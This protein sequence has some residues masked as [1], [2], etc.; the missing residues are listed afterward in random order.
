MKTHRVVV[1]HDG[2]T[3]IVIL[4]C[5]VRDGVLTVS[6]GEIIRVS[7]LNLNIR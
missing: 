4:N 5:E 7:A 2:L 6:V 3:Y 1:V